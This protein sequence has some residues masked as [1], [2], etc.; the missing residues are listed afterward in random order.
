MFVF[1]V[2]LVLVCELLGDGVFG[3]GNDLYLLFKGFV[4]TSTCGY[5]L[6]VTAT[7]FRSLM[8]I[9]FMFVVEGWSMYG[10]KYIG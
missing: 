6:S 8:G 7:V 5:T 2:L 10:C 9:V 4:L 3:V 1:V